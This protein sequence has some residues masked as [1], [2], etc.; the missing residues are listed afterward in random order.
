M[1]HDWHTCTACSGTFDTAESLAKHVCPA[2]TPAPPPP[3]PRPEPRHFED[4]T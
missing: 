1:G 2:H 4:A 3:P